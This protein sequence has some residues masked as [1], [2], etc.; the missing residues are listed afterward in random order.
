[1]E[2][3]IIR[4]FSNR[5]RKFGRREAIRYQTNTGEYQSLTWPELKTKVE[6]LLSSLQSIGCKKGDNIGIFSPNRAEWLIADLAIM[7]TGGVVVPMYATASGDQVGYIV[8]ET[9]MRVI[10]VGNIQQLNTVRSAPGVSSSLE[11]I[12]VFD[13]LATNDPMIINYKDFIQRGSANGYNATLEKQEKYFDK[14]DLATIIY[15]SG[16]TGEPKGAMLTHENFTY[17]FDI[18][19]KRLDISTSDVSLCFL[20]LSHVFERLW[21]HYLLNKGAVNVM[22][23]NP[24]EVINVLPIAKPTVMCTVP[25]F[26]DKTL[27][28]IQGEGK[29]WSPVKQKIFEWSLQQGYSAIEY[30]CRS[31]ALPPFLWFKHKLADTLVLKKLQK[32]FGGRMR[33]L[34][35][36]GAAISTETLKF[37]H[38]AGIFINYGYGAT[39]TT[40]TVS[41]FKSDKYVYGSCGTIMPGVEVKIGDKNEILVRGKSV[42]AGYYKKEEATKEAFTDGWFHTGDEGF[43]DDLGNLT[44][45]DRIRDMM[46]TSSGK[47]VSPQ[48]LELILGQDELVEQIIVVGDNKPFVSAIMVP[49]MAKLKDFAQQNNIAIDDEANLATN[50]ELISLIEKRF[51]SI[52]QTLTPYERVVRIALL[53]KPFSIENGTMTNTLKLRR[54]MIEKSHK[55]IIDRMYA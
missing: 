17:C 26:F 27:Q 18:H 38:A 8:R 47:F 50:P 55:E 34:P 15:T 32:F 28:G 43:M 36:S 48:K 21:S 41:C 3:H 53:P 9:S 12:V 33:V 5:V 29:K 42:F 51:E 22:L 44:M 13:E 4:M 10:F 19:D 54:R 30:R 16:T 14:N 24:K 37:F 20:P 7:A 35:C 52:Q 25:R 2:D 11:H 40:A 1:M 49:S 31:R 39:E 23:E 45:T 46:K 6:L